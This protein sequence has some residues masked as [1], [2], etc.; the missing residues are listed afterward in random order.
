MLLGKYIVSYRIIWST[1]KKCRVIISATNVGS[2]HHILRSSFQ[3]QII[4][5]QKPCLYLFNINTKWLVSL[6]CSISDNCTP[7]TVIKL[8]ITASCC[9]E[10]FDHILICLTDILD[11]FII[12]RIKFSCLLNVLRNDHLLIHLRRCRNGILCNGLFIFK[13][14]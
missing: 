5:F 14:L 1:C 10:L 11:Q 8:Q 3:C 6:L 12:C 2:N 13:L 4:Y 7:G 9:I